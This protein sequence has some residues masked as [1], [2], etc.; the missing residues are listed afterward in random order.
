MKKEIEELIWLKIN[1]AKKTT[2]PVNFFLTV[3]DL[4]D[5]IDLGNIQIDST[6]MLSQIK[7]LLNERNI[8][9]KKLTDQGRIENVKERKK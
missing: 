2:D 4:L 3:D 9:V 1:S 6:R 7:E 5:I 8:T